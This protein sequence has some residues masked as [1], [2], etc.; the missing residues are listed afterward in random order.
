MHTNVKRVVSGIQPSGI[1]H[2]GNY[3]GAIKNWVKYQETNPKNCYFFI[4]DYHSITTKFL[5]DYTESEKDSNYTQE[6]L[7]D[8]V[9][10]TAACLLACGLDPKKSNLFVQSHVPAHSNLMWLLSCLTPLSW[11]NKMVQFKEKKNSSNDLSS[12]GL[13]TYP[14]L[15]A[16]DILIY[17]ANIVPVG[18]DQIQHIEL[19]RDIANRIN[20]IAKFD[21]LPIPEYDVIKQSARIMSLQNGNVKMSKSD[22][23]SYACIS[24]IDNQEQIRN[25][26]MK[27]KTDSLGK[28]H[29][30]PKLRPEVSNLI[31]IYSNIM[32]LS[33]EDTVSKFEN[34]TT[35]EFKQELANS[36]SNTLLNI[37]EKS[38]HLMEKEAD[39]VKDVIREG[40][41]LAS[42]ESERNMNEIRK[43]MSFL[44]KNI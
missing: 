29:Y 3:L 5:K 10:K 39:Y 41:I 1:L 24:L 12:T 36:L 9:F 8:M 18:E 34:A 13:Y 42:E 44:L 17:K 2:I 31:N 16:A 7:D 28:I 32:N 37:S 22:K 33:I 38:I 35:F 40:C 27:A 4:A 43:Y 15:M 26:I 25:K 20:K 19:T 14:V 23:S 30:D 11:L 6:K 21:V